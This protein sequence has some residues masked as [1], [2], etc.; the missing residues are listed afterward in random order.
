[1]AGT[2]DPIRHVCSITIYFLCKVLGGGEGQATQ[3]ARAIVKKQ[4]ESVARKCLN[5]LMSTIK[6]MI[7]RVMIDIYNIV[8]LHVEQGGMEAKV[9]SPASRDGQ[10]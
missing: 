4:T 9:A 6:T 3:Q 8:K 7:P 2:F 5:I 1:M 10:P